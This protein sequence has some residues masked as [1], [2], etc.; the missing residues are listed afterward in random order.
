VPKIIVAALYKFAKLPDYQALQPGLLNHCIECGL[1]GTLLLAE[2]GINGTVAG[3]RAG[4]DALMCYLKADQRLA[5]IEHKESYADE[6]PFTR[7]KV[8]LKKEIVTLG[9]PGI[10]PNNKVGTYVAPEDWNALISD[11]DVVL[12]DTRNG[13]ECDIGT[14]RRAI[15][16]HTT[17]FR[18]FPAYINNNFN[19]A[20]HKKI[21]MFC[22]GGIRCEKASSLMV[23]RG[24]EQVYHLQ[25]GILKYLEKIP[26]AESLWEGE[27]F[28]FDQRIS[29]GHG[30]KVGAY[31]QCH[32]CRH[33]V[34]PEDKESEKYV[35]GVSCPH[36]FESLT[37]EKRIRFSERQKQSELAR[38]AGRE[39]IGV[40]QKK[41]K[42]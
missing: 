28:V 13:Y 29:V 34:S 16:P 15:D 42:E 12:I 33:P 11:P 4:I 32:G 20:K 3:S 8:K 7:I 39:H 19:P 36:C 38:K 40:V 21:A 6:M 18:E 9:V 10:N 30:L 27:C 17:N 25:G 22:T 5:D 41:R 37:E 24:F 2:E 26:P 14:F 1:Y 31:A 35:E 23:E